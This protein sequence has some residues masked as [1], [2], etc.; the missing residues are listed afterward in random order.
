[1]L[2]TFLFLTKPLKKG[3]VGGQQW[4]LTPLI[5]AFERKREVGLCEF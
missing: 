5:L 3:R 4:W 2:V 1:M